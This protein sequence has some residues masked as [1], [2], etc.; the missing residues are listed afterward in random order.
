MH[1]CSIH[2]DTPHIPHK[3]IL[4]GCPCYHTRHRTHSLL[5]LKLRVRKVCRTVKSV[6]NAST[7]LTGIACCGLAGERPASFLWNAT[8]GT[9]CLT[10]HCGQM[11]IVFCSDF[12]RIRSRQ[13]LQNVWQH[14]STLGSLNSSRHTLHVR[15]S[16]SFSA[17]LSQYSS[18]QGRII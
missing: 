2:T 16:C 7:P 17:I 13:P 9:G 5:V 6:G 18:N 10:L 11:S 4:V 8:T 14:G 1:H 3:M 15:S 12:S